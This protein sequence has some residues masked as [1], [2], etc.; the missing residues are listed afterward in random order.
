[1]ES[2]RA[3]TCTLVDTSLLPRGWRL[4]AVLF[5]LTE[6]NHIVSGLSS[7]L[8]FP[9]RPWQSDFAFYLQYS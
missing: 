1:M 5:R 8:F 4:W 7:V 6:R 3:V 2:F 9:T